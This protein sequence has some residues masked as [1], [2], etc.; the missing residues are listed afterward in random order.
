MSLD[1]FIGNGIAIRVELRFHSVATLPN[2]HSAFHM[3]ALCQPSSS[4][5]AGPINLL[6]GFRTPP[7]HRTVHWSCV[8]LECPLA[9]CMRVRPATPLILGN[10]GWLSLVCCA[11]VMEH[12]H[13]A[14]QHCLL[15]TISCFRLHSCLHIYLAC[16][17]RTRIA[18]FIVVH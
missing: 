12:A 11:L 15:C 6:T 13:V 1:G 8:Q 7:G 3:S 10:C 18:D 14:H 2:H 9:L 5:E 16:E 17:E 4:Q